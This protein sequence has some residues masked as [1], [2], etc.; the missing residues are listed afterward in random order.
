MS[1][2]LQRGGGPRDQCDRVP[3]RRKQVSE[4]FARTWSDA[5][6]D[7][8][9]RCARV[10]VVVAQLRRARFGAARRCRRCAVAQGSLRCCASLSSLRSCAGLASVLRVAVVVAQLRRSRFGASTV[11]RMDQR[12]YPAANPS[13]GRR[14][15][16]LLRR[17]KIGG[18]GSAGQRQSRPAV[19]LDHARASLAFP[20]FEYCLGARLISIV[21]QDFAEP[22]ARG[23]K[24][25]QETVAPLLERRAPMAV[26]ER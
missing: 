23:L 1:T 8:R 17:L 26:N 21:Q 13:G 4:S 3:S 5:D 22:H 18:A 6:Y 11:G 7:R 19:I 24:N 16:L 12:L 14:S 9:C 20:A 25:G 10:A 15:A 2:V